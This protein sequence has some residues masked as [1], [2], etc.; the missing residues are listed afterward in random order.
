MEQAWREKEGI[1]VEEDV[2]SAPAHGGPSSSSSL[3]T[4]MPLDWREELTKKEKTGALKHP[5]GENVYSKALYLELIVN[6]Q[7]KES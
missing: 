3:T 1:T 5:T 4:T 2:P 6:R 7:A